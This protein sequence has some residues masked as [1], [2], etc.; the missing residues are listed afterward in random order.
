MAS[1]GDSVPLELVQQL[2]TCD[3]PTN[4]VDMKMIRYCVN[5]I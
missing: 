2:N 3:I 4:I 1:G 5:A